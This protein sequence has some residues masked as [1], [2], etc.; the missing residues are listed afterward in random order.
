MAEDRKQSDKYREMT[1][2]PVERLIIRLAIPSTISLLVTS[3]YNLADTYFVGQLGNSATGAVG[4]VYPLMTIINAIGLMFGKGTGTI[5]GRQLGGRDNGEAART[6]AQG[7]IFS[8]LLGSLLMVS[9]LMFINPLATLLGT[10]ESMRPYTIVY[11]RYI[12]LAM[13]FKAAAT[14]LSFSLRFQGYSSRATWGLACGAILN[15]ILDPLLISVA[16]WGLAGAAIATMTGE[17]VSCLTL[18]W[19][20][21]RP[22]CVPLRLRNMLPSIGSLSSICRNGFSSLIKHSLS[23]VATIML[24]TAAGLYG[25]AAVAAFTI[26]SRLV[27]IGQ[28]IYFGISDGYQPV[29]S[30]NYGAGFYERIRRGY[31]FCIRIGGLLVILVALACAFAEPIIAAFRDDAEVVALGAQILRVQMLTLTLLPVSSAGFVMLQGIGRNG[32]AAILGS[33]RQGLFLVP[34]LLILPRVWGLSGLVAV[35]P[36]SDILATIL[37]AIIL[38]PNLRQLRQ[39]EEAKLNTTTKEC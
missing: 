34:L 6:M 38:R 10:T 15:I 2:T 16:G 29:C 33:G 24:N 32:H 7:F 20:A 39:L 3:V 11:A 1:E 18:L 37:S 30:Y 36:C 14:C 12:L 8:V 9:G 4:L 35:Q 23:S 25:D 26:V 19:M 22:G 31:W 17:I 27:H 5:L 28:M 21:T 13:P